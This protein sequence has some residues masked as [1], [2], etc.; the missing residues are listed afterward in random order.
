MIWQLAPENVVVTMSKFFHEKAICSC[1]L[2]CLS[3]LILSA[4]VRAQDQKP[5]PKPDVVRVETGLVQTDVMVLDKNHRFVKGL[6]PSQ[7]RLRVNDKPREILFFEQVVAGSRSED[8]RLAAARGR[9]AG[10]EGRSLVSDRGRTIYFYIDDYHLSAKSVQHVRELLTEF[11]QQV[12]QEED[13]V[14]IV[15]ATGQLGFFEQP[16]RE[17]VV[18]LKAI[19]NLNHKNF[20]ATDAERTSMTEYQAR[21]I[22]GGD[23]R[24]MDYFV[25]QLLKETA[26]PRPRTGS[27]QIT[28]SRGRSETENRVMSRAQAIVEQIA[29]YS[30]AT[31]LG[32]D[33]LM[34]SAASIP[35][36]KI[37]FLISEGFILDKKVVSEQAEG[38]ISDA[39]ARSGTVI[40]AIDATGLMSGVPSAATKMTFDNFGRLMGTNVSGIVA[41]QQ[42]L[43]ALS[44]DSGGRAFI[45][46]NNITSSAIAEALQETNEYYLLA[47][48]PEE[49][50]VRSGKY[51]SISLEIVERPEL[52]LRGRDGFMSASEPSQPVK[53]D[54]NSKK[55]AS[56][57]LASALHAIFPQR[58]LPVSLSLGYLDTPEKLATVTAT[59]EVARAAL[60]NQTGELELLGMVINEQGKPVS[61]FDQGLTISDVS[62]RV[63]YNHQMQFAPGLYQVRVAVR[64]KKGGRVGSASEWIS[65]PNLKDGSFALS[66]LFIGEMNDEAMASGKLPINADHRFRANSR[67]GLFTYIYNPQK[68][69]GA[70][71]VGLQIQILRDN[72]P[73]IT[74]PSIKLEDA[75]NPDPAR[76]PF[77]EDL[78]LAQLPAGKYLLRVTVIDRLSKKT[79]TQSSRFTIY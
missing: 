18:L 8:A 52:Q 14:T 24:L 61:T 50:E 27:T 25:E 62:Q 77:G 71:D 16:T 76:I 74:K 57:P 4:T 35:D 66:S 75:G 1:F 73:V 7:F 46:T 3:L 6:Q 78:S 65:V 5:E 41:A 79:V 11:L 28:Q 48:R 12:K 19:S 51:H 56:D 15:T 49:E 22:V 55:K 60:G 59:I 67:L 38:Q 2:S 26:L 29:S 58:D 30:G 37:L 72:Q 53:T 68:L 20:L 43:F 54:G 33:R 47:W 63:T 36:R 44:V 70:S 32:L 39:A 64:D 10:A 45:N 9:I 21:A 13:E 23:R 17:N 34:R 69:E 42:P 31:L 40:Y